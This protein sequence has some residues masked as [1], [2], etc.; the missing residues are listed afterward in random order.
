MASTDPQAP[1]GSYS[2]DHP[3]PTVETISSFP[4]IRTGV[5][6]P[7]INI[8]SSPTKTD[9]PIAGQRDAVQNGGEKAASPTSPADR[10]L[11]ADEWGT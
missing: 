11:S 7:T 3:S 1:Q 2:P 5:E 8:D 6:K 9:G 4:R 10:R